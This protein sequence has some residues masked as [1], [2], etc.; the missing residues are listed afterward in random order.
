MGCLSP[1]GRRRGWWDNLDGIVYRSRTTPRSSI[2]VAFF[3]HASF[4]V[5]SQPLRVCAHELDESV[6]PL[7]RSPIYRASRT[8]PGGR[9]GVTPAR[10]ARR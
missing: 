1:I 6:S 3:S 8:G 5:Q 9:I 7:D 4:T 10:F 2:N